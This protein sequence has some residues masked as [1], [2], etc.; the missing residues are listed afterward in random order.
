M[1]QFKTLNIKK[2]KT[3]DEEN[4][5][6]SFVFSTGETDRQ[7]QVVDQS[8]FKLSSFLENPVVLFAH[9]H[10]R[11]A[12]GN[13]VDIG[14]GDTGNLEGKIKF[15]A[16]E[17]EF[18]R[19]LW[20]LYKNGFMRAVSIGFQPEEIQGNGEGDVLLGNE[21]YEVSL[22]NVP[23]NAR[24]LAKEKGI[25]I[26][27]LEEEEK[28][29]A[30]NQAEVLEKL[31]Q[32]ARKMIK[33]IDSIIEPTKEAHQTPPPAEKTAPEEVE[34]GDAENGSVEP[35]L[36][37]PTLEEGVESA[38]ES[39]NQPQS[40]G[41]GEESADNATEKVDIQEETPEVARAAKLEKKK[42]L[43]NKRIRELL[44]VKKKLKKY[45]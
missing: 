26:A 17:Y 23:A 18:A 10:N 13:V 45:E 16:E 22:V 32:E 9:D 42:R 15:A 6:L 20:S 1:M 28:R 44:E 43:V 40:D 19:V 30:K 24:S 34:S 14:F 35:D 21:L 33:E 3:V 2:I 25:D 37:S 4:Y 39:Q 36:H 7:G 29:V 11:P 27:P 31:R 12:V 8:T 5:T 38:E 41:V